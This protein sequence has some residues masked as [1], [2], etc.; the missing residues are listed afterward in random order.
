MFLLARSGRNNIDHVYDSFVGL[1]DREVYLC[2][3][4]EGELKWFLKS[5]IPTEVLKEYTERKSD[6]NETYVCQIDKTEMYSCLFKCKTRGFILSAFDCGIILAYRDMYGAE[7]L[8]Q[9][10]YMYLDIVQA[11]IGISN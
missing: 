3:I 7:S 5:D 4:V 8:T 2:R 6:T 10:A 11:Y 9:I 1:D